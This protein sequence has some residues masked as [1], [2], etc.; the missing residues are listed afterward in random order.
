MADDDSLAPQS[1]EPPVVARLVV[2]I[3]SD[4]SR[5]I[6]RGAMEDAITGEKVAIEARG[7]SPLSLALGLAK[8]MTRGRAFARSAVRA[9]LPRPRKK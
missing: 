3:R 8:S 1:D 9:I 2:E 4:G 7:T 6:A 5:T